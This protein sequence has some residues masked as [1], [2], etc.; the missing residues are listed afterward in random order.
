MPLLRGTWYAYTLLYKVKSI[1]G[2][3][4]ANIFTQGRFTKVVPM[5]ARSD[6]GQS[7]LDFTDDFGIPKRLVTDGIVEFTGRGKQFVKEACHMR[8][9]LHTR[10]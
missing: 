5:T 6:A 8:I 2:N 7:L 3:T 4:C 9:Q 10:K 1:R